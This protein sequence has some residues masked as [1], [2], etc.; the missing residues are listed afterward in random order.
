MNLKRAVASGVWLE[1]GFKKW[2]NISIEE[3]RI[4]ALSGSRIEILDAFIS[5]MKDRCASQDH[6]QYLIDFI[7]T[8]YAAGFINDKNLTTVITKLMKIEK[9]GNLPVN[10]RGIFGYSIHNDNSPMLSIAINPDLDPYR[11]EL[12][13]FHEFTHAVLDGNSDFMS[14]TARNT[15]AS[16]EQQVLFADGYTVIEEAVA[17]NTAEQM[18]AKLYGRNRALYAQSTDAI[19]PGV[20]FSTNFDYYGLYQPIGNTFARTLS[21]IGC[22]RNRGDNDIYLNALSARAFNGGFAEGIIKEYKS[23]GHFKELAIS[24]VKLGRVYEA[25]QASFGWNNTSYDLSKI[26]D[27]YLEALGSFNELENNRP[28][29]EQDSI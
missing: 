6:L 8:G 9:F 25:K 19:I 1:K 27:Y 3:V 24:F 20:K 12:Y 14:K 11:K 17:Q 23:R 7:S 10:Q 28:Q 4:M 2:Y 15:G 18:M 29:Q 5:E 22:L 26:R 21:G 13:A 16:P